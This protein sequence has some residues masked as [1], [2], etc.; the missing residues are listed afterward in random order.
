LQARQEG[1]H[2]F[3]LGY[4]KFWDI[5]TFDRK[6]KKGIKITHVAQEACE[7]CRKLPVLP[8]QIAKLT[9]D[10]QARRLELKDCVVFEKKLKTLEA[11]YVKAA[12]HFKW[13][14]NNRKWIDAVTDDLT[15]GRAPQTRQIIFDF[16]KFYATDSRAVK[17]LTL[18]I[19]GNVEPGLACGQRTLEFCDNWFRGGSTGQTVVRIFEHLLA[20]MEL[21][22]IPGYRTYL[23]SDT[24]NG[25]RGYQF[26]YFLSTCWR[27]FEQWFE[28]VGFTPRHAWG[29]SD[30][31]FG[32]LSQMLDAIKR[33]SRIVELV[34]YANTS[35]KLPNTFSYIHGEEGGD[36]FSLD[37]DDVVFV[38]ELVH[39]EPVRL[40]KP[41]GLKS[42][43]QAQFRWQHNTA[44][45]DNPTHPHHPNNL[46][47]CFVILVPPNNPFRPLSLITLTRPN[48]V[49][50]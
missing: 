49:T 43:T 33:N 12:R 15:W 23:S 21:F 8:G 50:P 38:D 45:N 7:V 48:I 30:T 16:G 44:D 18:S 4:A 42:I 24:G 39:P 17:S 6:T 40:R 13:Y 5:I 27:R 3:P 25:N 32:L 10:I 37:D 41:P 1:R 9:S 26:F 46:S 14:T 36:K 35:A 28:W 11:D 22:Q 2:L 31:H 47:T 29:W 19:Q 20:N 34:E